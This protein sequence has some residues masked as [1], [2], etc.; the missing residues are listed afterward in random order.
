ML[1]NRKLT[2]KR[3]FTVPVLRIRRWSLTQSR[4]TRLWSLE[5]LS[6]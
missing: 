2:R 6:G 3:T 4:I 1:A 5:Q